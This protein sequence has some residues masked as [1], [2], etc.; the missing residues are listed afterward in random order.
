MTSPSTSIWRMAQ[1]QCREACQTIC[2]IASCCSEEQGRVCPSWPSTP[3]TL[4]SRQRQATITC[5]TTFPSSR[6][7]SSC[8]RPA[9]QQ[10]SSHHAANLFSR[11][12]RPTTAHNQ[13]TSREPLPR[14]HRQSKQCSALPGMFLT[15]L[16]RSLKMRLCRM[17]TVAATAA[18]SACTQFQGRV[19]QGV[20]VQ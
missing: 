19:K 2:S 15:P 14:V 3:T 7:S 1:W 11:R 17:R 9:V 6:S 5:L 13:S 8:R 20:W 10:D 12:A 18:C 4:G 16:T